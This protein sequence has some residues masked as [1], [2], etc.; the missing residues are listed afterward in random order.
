MLALAYI[1]GV[2]QKLDLITAAIAHAFA[3]EGR[4]C[5]RSARVTDHQRLSSSGY[6]FSASLPPYLASAAITAIDVLEENPSLLTK[7]KKSVAVLRKG[8]L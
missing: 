1:S 2:L 6:V 3:T 7:L 5:T 4:F 8:R